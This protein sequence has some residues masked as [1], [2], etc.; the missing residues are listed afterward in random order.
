[1]DAMAG[2]VSA[3][4]VWFAVAAAATLAASSVFAADAENGER[5]AR[6]W[7][8]SCHLVAPN[9]P[10]PT[11]EAPPFSTIAGRAEFD[12]AKVAFFLLDPHPK[13]PNM[14]L[15]RADAADLAAYIATLK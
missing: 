14:G 9:Q 6:R 12:S 1:M 8:S 7:C 3:V 4:P 10:G 15:S 13:M 5:L 2:I 11:T